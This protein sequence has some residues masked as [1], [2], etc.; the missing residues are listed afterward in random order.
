MGASTP[1]NMCQEADVMWLSFCAKEKR[2]AKGER[3]NCRRIKQAR[4]KSRSQGH[5]MML[6]VCNPRNHPA[7]TAEA[8]KGAYEQ[9]R[10]RTKTNHTNSWQYGHRSAG[11]C[12]ATGQDF[13]LSPMAA[14]AA[15]APCPP[16]VCSFGF[17]MFSCVKKPPFLPCRLPRRWSIMESVCLCHATCLPELRESV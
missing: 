4:W 1:Q 2:R 14:H 13:S 7:A 15:A 12:Q 10:P 17:G 11:R 9:N 3:T 6:A 8:E 5:A 16:A